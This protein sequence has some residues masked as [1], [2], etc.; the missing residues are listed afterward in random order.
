MADKQYL[1]EDLL[2]GTPEHSKFF[3]RKEQKRQDYMTAELIDKYGPEAHKVIN[4]AINTELE[5]REARAIEILEAAF[6]E[7]YGPEAHELV[8]QTRPKILWERTPRN[9][10]TLAD[11]VTEE[12][13]A[14]AIDV[15]MEGNR[16]MWVELATQLMDELNIRERNCIGAI[17]ILTWSHRDMGRVAEATPKRAVREETRCPMLPLF[18]ADWCIRATQSSLLGIANAVN[19]NITLH[20]DEFTCKGGSICRAVFELKE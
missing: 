4:E 14:E 19:S 7:K 8:E 3:A 18:G 10:I 1:Y 2:L 5:K 13:G 16:K 17:K 12:Y 6:V 15:M 9:I 11:F 20:H